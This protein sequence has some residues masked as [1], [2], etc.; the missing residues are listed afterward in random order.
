MRQE[1][2]NYFKYLNRY[3][4]EPR[5]VKRTKSTFV[6]GRL[7]D[8]SALLDKAYTAW[9][10]MD[11][12]R[13]ERRRNIEYRNGNQWSDMVPD[14]DNS[15]KMIRESE[16]LTRQGK[17]LLKHNFIQQFIRNISG[18]M[19][20]NPT[21]SVVYARTEG[22]EELGEMLTNTL[23]ACH[24][25]NRVGRVDLALLE[26]LILSGVGCY[27]VGYKFS[28][29]R[30]QGE[31]EVD[32]VPGSRLFVDTD[33]SDASLRSLSLIGELHELSLEE[34]ISTFASN[35]EEEKIVGRIYTPLAASTVGVSNK[36]SDFM[37]PN[38]SACCRVIEVWYREGRW[39]KHTHDYLTGES[40]RE[41]K[42]TQKEV[43]KINRERLAECRSLGYSEERAPLLH[44]DYQY[45]HYWSV[46]FL[47]PT[48]ELLYRGE[49]PY[50]HKSHPYI[51][52]S[53]PTIDGTPKA[54]VSD[55]IDIQR[56]IN[57]LIVMID[58]IMG[59][60]AKGVL[61]VPEN[62]LPDG[63]SIE[64][65]TSEY[66]KANGVILY[67]PNHTR[68]VPFQIS[69]NSTNVGAW[70]ML[71]I[72]IGLIKE[73]SG[74]SGAIQGEGSKGYTASSL[75]AQQAEN[76]QLNLKVLFNT[77][78]LLQRDRDEKMLKVIMQYYRNERYL[79]P[80]F[81]SGG[82][83]SK[84]IPELVDTI[85]DFDLV[86]SHSI[87]TPLYRQLN[88]EILKSM[89][90]RGQ[91]DIEMFLSNSSLPFAESLLSQLRQKSSSGK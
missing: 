5:G 50:N 88:E 76:S 27:K 4:V 14:P 39:V 31:C 82:K 86:V 59:T 47:A 18:Q 65:F 43:D 68:D 53:I 45:E 54:L 34:V 8:G 89:L 46:A 12:F 2:I 77:L 75:Y 24:D 42:I 17:S 49:S 44:L 21:Q 36:D 70:E 91:I 13:S 85:I 64:D 15:G 32:V 48:G 60:S 87:A 63:Y 55:V 3:A 66:V 6:K 20:T 7:E 37:T 61:M 19:L 52:G 79:S 69:S 35:P 23:Q 40:K 73:L 84:Y 22:K 25:S 29:E 10:A 1:I 26:E 57:R 51:I 72:Q 71:N 67:K 78:R 80:A 30:E 81:E 83:E 9:L 38:D 28:S 56:Y 16:L 58:F 33:M 11:T 74:V 41:D 90:D 62:A